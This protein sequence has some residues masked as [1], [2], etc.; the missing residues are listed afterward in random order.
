MRLSRDTLRAAYED[1]CRREIE[2][3]KPG[4]VHLFADGH[5][6]SAD[7][8]LDQRQRLLR[9]AH[10]S[11]PAGRAA[12]SR[13]GPRDT[14]GGRDQHQSRHR[15]ALRPPAPR[16]RDGGRRLPRESRRGSRRDGHGGHG[17]G[18]RGN[19]ARLA[20]RP[21][22]GRRARCR[23][24]AEGP[25]ARSDAGSGRARQDRPPVRHPLRRRVR[26]RARR[27]SKRRSLAARAACGRL[28]SPIWRSLP[29]FR[30]ATWRAYTAIEIASR[31]REEA[32][33]VRASLDAA[34]DEAA[35]IGLLMDFDRRLKARAINPGTSA[36]LTV[37][38]LLVHA[39]EVHL[40]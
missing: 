10:R 17:G 34:G 23:A 5:R 20:R 9:P 32:I 19:R 35:R 2:A 38:S 4:N 27:P 6:M 30:T 28:S 36:D 1:A 25:S 33:A 37:A 26:S 40:A 3:L 29:A 14:P 15:P 7:Q 22:I 12:H 39:L 16:R 8:F 31:V 21:W 18:V 24:R 13:S 11:R